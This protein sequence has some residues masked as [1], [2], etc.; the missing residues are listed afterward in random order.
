MPPLYLKNALFRLFFE[1]GSNQVSH[2]T[3]TSVFY[4]IAVSFIWLPTPVFLAFPCG[5]AGIESTCNVGD[6]GS[7]S[8]SGRSPWRRKW[9]PTPVFLAFPCGSAGKESTCHTVDLGS[10]PVWFFSNCGATVGF[11]TRYDGVLREPLVWY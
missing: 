11:L 1:S 8:G 3:L 9:Q 2:L 10:I 5:S 4:C 7:I 6:L